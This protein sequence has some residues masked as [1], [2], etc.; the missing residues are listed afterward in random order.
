[1]HCFELFILRDRNILTPEV[2][3]KKNKSKIYTHS[4]HLEMMTNHRLHY[5]VVVLVDTN[6][7]VR[8]Q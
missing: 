1:M 5:R 6:K 4:F 2:V 8:K 3:Q 7:E